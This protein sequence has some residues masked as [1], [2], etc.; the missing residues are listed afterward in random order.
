MPQAVGGGTE[1]GSLAFEASI[2]SRRI[3]SRPDGGTRGQGHALS[4]SRPLASQPIAVPG[5]ARRRLNWL[6]GRRGFVPAVQIGEA[7]PA[8]SCSVAQRRSCLGSGE[9]NLRPRSSCASAMI[10][11]PG[12]SRFP[13][14]R[15]SHDVGDRNFGPVRC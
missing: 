11:F 4:V 2:P 8:E 10:A 13:F 1:P 14:R 12:R 3:C 7:L 6:R 9:G 15:D 5:G